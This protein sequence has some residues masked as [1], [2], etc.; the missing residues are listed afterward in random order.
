MPVHIWN[1]YLGSPSMLFLTAS[2]EVIRR[3]GRHT[4]QMPRGKNERLGNKTVAIPATT[5]KNL[6]EL[7]PF[8]GVRSTPGHRTSTFTE[9]K[10]CV[11]FSSQR[12]PGAAD[13]QEVTAA[14]RGQ[15]GAPWV[16]APNST[17][18]SPGTHEN[19]KDGTESTKY[20]HT[21]THTRTH[22]HK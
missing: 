22:T 21:C 12:A 10:E 5:I 9:G 19:V 6:G 2:N 8:S 16:K 1:D 20:T 4:P 11:Y 14:M 13:D 18:L 3:W 7:G 17:S 15:K